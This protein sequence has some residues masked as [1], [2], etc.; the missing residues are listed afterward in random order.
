M[1]R[2]NTPNAANPDNRQIEWVASF[3]VTGVGELQ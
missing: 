1:S 2:N 3:R